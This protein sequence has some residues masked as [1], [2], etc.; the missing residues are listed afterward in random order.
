VSQLIQFGRELASH[1][2]ES[3]LT[4]DTCTHA[5]GESVYAAHA[6]NTSPYKSAT[7]CAFC[8]FGPYCCLIETRCSQ[9]NNT[10][11]T[12]QYDENV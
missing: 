5:F 6:P 3:T 10:Q 9:A 12:D 1:H 8:S 11:L 2:R 4:H 7:S